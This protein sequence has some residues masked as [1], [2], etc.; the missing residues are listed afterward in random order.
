MFDTV[1]AH[2]RL[3]LDHDRL[4]RAGF[5][6]K[7]SVVRDVEGKERES[8]F[9]DLHLAHQSPHLIQYLP[10]RVPDPDDPASCLKLETS[11]PKAVFGENVSMLAPGDVDRALDLI[12][13]RVSDL[14]G[15]I[16]HLSQWAVRGRLDCAF[17]WRARG[18]VQE[19]LH[20]FKVLQLPR[21]HTDSV[22][23]DATI[24]WRNSQRLMRLYDKFKETGLEI[25][26]DIL[27]FEVQE[28][29]AKAELKRLAGESS[30]KLGDVLTWEN[31]RVI[32]QH[33]LDSLGADLVIGDR[34]KFIHLLLERCS[35]AKAERLLGFAEMNQVY[36]RDEQLRMGASR[37]S[38]WRKRRE[39]RDLGAS[40]A[41][42]RSGILP[43]LVLPKTYTG[44]PL[45]LVG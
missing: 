43:P 10:S 39:L 21:H 11:L 42:S 24:Y 31:A 27:R 9:Y 5:T 4:L 26:K 14:V 32:I 37:I 30:T 22:D 15:D 2:T 45:E 23:V 29:H 35:F 25:A 19:Y 44:E 8:K 40:M 38:V 17:N 3:E 18:L 34:E 7:S 41:S 28:N 20:A 13:N 12:S 1:R 16:P 6:L 33:Y 36:S